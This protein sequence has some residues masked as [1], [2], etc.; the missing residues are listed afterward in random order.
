MGGRLRLPVIILSP[1]NYPQ[2]NFLPPEG[3][4]FPERCTNA[5]MCLLQLSA[6]MMQKPALQMCGFPNA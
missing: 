1:G 2:D 3:A 4:V 6:F 5:K